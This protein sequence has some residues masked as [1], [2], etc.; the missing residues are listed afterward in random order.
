[1]KISFDGVVK[2][3]F[4]SLHNHFGA[5]QAVVLNFKNSAQVPQTD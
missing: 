2:G 1:M 4:Q 5:L 3:L